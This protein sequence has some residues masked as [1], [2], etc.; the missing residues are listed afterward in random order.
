MQTNIFEGFGL[1][2]KKVA[3]SIIIVFL[4]L[5]HLQTVR[6]NEVTTYI[7]YRSDYAEFLSYTYGFIFRATSPIDEIKEHIVLDVNN[8]DFQF[9]K[10]GYVF[11]YWLADTGPYV[12]HSPVGSKLIVTRKF[13]EITLTAHWKGLPYKVY[14]N[15]EGGTGV[16][17][18]YTDVVMGTPYG[19]LQTPQRDGYTFKGWFTETLGRGTQITSESLVNTPNN[20]TLYAQWEKIVKITFDSNGGATPELPSKTV[21]LGSPYGELP[22]SYRQGYIFD[23]WWLED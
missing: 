4:S 20:H 22:L 2:C 15:S 7:T 19:T 10:S 3:A 14:F 16:I 13:Q 6:A 23:G 9:H 5:T 8:T 11:D 12:F 21:P 17:P 1:H 18:S